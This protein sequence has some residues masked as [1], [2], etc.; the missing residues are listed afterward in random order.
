MVGSDMRREGEQMEGRR[1]EGSGIRE[2]QEEDIR[3]K[4]E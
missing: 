4:E 3:M 2:R 1:T